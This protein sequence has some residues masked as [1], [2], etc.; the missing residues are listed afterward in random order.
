VVKK[1]LITLGIVVVRLLEG[2]LL[3]LTPEMEKAEET[4]EKN[5][6]KSIGN[7]ADVERLAFW[8]HR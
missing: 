5:H 8:I 4:E 2:Y 3:F 1:L 6:W 7:D